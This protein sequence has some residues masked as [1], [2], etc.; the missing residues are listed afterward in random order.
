ML[1][2][3]TKWSIFRIYYFDSKQVISLRVISGI[4]KGRILKSV[5]GKGTRP[6]TDK[7]K[8]SV[9]NMIG[10]YFAGGRGL[11]LFAGSGSLGI[12]GIS[13]G[14][15]SVIFVDADRRA[16]ETI[17]ENLARCQFEE[18][19]EVYRADWK[20]ALHI[21][22]KRNLQFKII[23]LDPPYHKHI[24]ID[25]LKKVCKNELI[26]PNG[27]IVCEHERSL[28]LPDQVEALQRIKFVEYGTISVS[29]YQEGEW[30]EDQEWNGLPSVQ[31]V[32]IRLQTVI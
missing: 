13:R 8:E 6:T 21:I 14:L 27:L 22:S 3:V 24:Y 15:D 11:D 19:A 25:V 20:K 28:K 12:E 30:K 29:I 18:Q 16:I 5:P 2:L 10:P 23:W 7:V 32:L 9:F 17:R 4:Q 31:E 26:E 1:A